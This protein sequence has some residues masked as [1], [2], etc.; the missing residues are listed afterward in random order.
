M[1]NGGIGSVQ[2]GSFCAATW[3]VNTTVASTAAGV[4]RGIRLR[5]VMFALHRTEA[6]RRRTPRAS[7]PCEQPLE[8]R[9][10][11]QRR[12]GG[13]DLEPAGREVVRDGQQRL[14]P[15]GGPP[16]VS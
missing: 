4:V 8:P 11:T 13:V 1:R 15:A 6:S 2:L 5:G 3:P 9:V 16:R 10:A 7:T 14:Q 12:E